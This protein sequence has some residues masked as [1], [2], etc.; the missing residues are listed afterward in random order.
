[1]ITAAEALALARPTKDDIELAREAMKKI[2]HHIRNKMTFAGPEPLE[3]RPDEMNYASAKLVAVA[4][5]QDGWNVSASLGVKQGALGGKMTIWQLLFSPTIETYEIAVA[6]FNIS[7]K[8]L[9][10]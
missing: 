6:E 7:P 1:M 4:M 9:D 2:D 8:H 10:A 5:K 3:L